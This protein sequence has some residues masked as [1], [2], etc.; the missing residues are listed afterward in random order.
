MSATT[1]P[2]QTSAGWLYSPGFDRTFIL[3]VP[4]LALL[5]GTY[6]VSRPEHLG[7]VLA[8]NLWL[9]GY[10]HV[11]ATFTRIA[12]DRRSLRENRF[13]VFVAPVLVLAGTVALA[14]GVGAW[15]VPTLY[16]YW[17]WFHYTRQSW[18]VS[19]V[20]GARAMEPPDESPL[21][22]KLCLYLVPT[23]G[24]LF[25]TA[26]APAEFLGAE[27]RVPYIPDWVVASIGA[28]AG[29]SVAAWCFTR[30]RAWWNGQLAIAHTLYM[31]SHFVV[32]F[33]GY[34][35]IDDLTVGWL[36]INIW[37]NA[38]Y[39]LFV[40]LFNTRRFAGGVDDQAGY[41]SRLSQPDRMLRYFANCLCIATLVY[42]TSLVWV[43]D[44]TW[45]GLP[46]VALLY[47][48]INFHHYV[49][50]AKIWK[51]RKGPLKA[52]LKLGASG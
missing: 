21:F 25:R 50:D 23:W 9:L 20:Y 34:R 38:Q 33:V 43:F 18:G 48:A 41:L 27:I 5:A 45:L 16:L 49:V 36:V 14:L 4:A 12:F 3:G 24:I 40:W 28:A 30:V 52:T 7:F 35:W 19:Q 51:V 15:A 44:R 46:A 22:A 11:I 47:P 10:H 13:L 29:L 2:L 1:H 37:H 17:Q 32:F 26:Q 8:A 42:A 6:V 39:L 31:L